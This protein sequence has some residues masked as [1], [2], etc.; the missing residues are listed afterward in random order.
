M[1][2][3]TVANNTADSDGDGD[4]DGGGIYAPT[5]GTFNARNS[6]FGNNRDLSGAGTV[7]PDCSGLFFGVGYNLIEDVAGCTLGG[8]QVGYVT[9]LDP[10]L[11]PL[12]G[13]G[14][15]TLTRAL[16]AGSPAIDAGNPLRLHRSQRPRAGHRPAR[17][18]AQRP[19]RHR[20]LRVRL[21]R[22]ADPGPTRRRPRRRR[23]RSP[24]PERQPA[25][26]RRRAARPRPAPRRGPPPS[27]IPHPCRRPPRPLPA[28]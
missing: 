7:H 9:G 4:G 17:L 27:P 5:L 11:G 19:L 23:A 1:F 22:H 20:R 3:V 21:A 28:R 18:L 25:P 15:S 24:A 12:Q 6:L 2:S 14:G 26:S 13:N 10:D 8:S 16:L